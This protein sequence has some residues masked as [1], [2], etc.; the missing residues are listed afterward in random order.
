MRVAV[1]WGGGKDSCFALHKAVE[2]GFEVNRLLTY[3]YQEPYI[4]HSFKLMELQSQALGVPQQKVKIKDAMRDVYNALATLKHE[5]IEGIVT[6][7]IANVNH[8]PFYESA[9]KQIGLE[10]FTPLWDPAGNHVNLLDEE[11]SAGIKF[12]FGCIDTKYARDLDGFAKKWLGHVCDSECQKELLALCAKNKLD[13]CGE[14]PTAWYHTMVVDAPLF[15]QRIEVGKF[16]LKKS[17]KHR[18]IGVKEAS[19]KPKF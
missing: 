13:P 7:D 17:G 18:Y 14:T 12:I 15:R 11:L 3:V 1:H 16:D 19:L 5:G 2:R 6:G 9:C 4:F 10:L 8:K